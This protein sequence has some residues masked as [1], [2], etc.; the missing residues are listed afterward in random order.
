M[1][2]LTSSTKE[3]RQAIS[4]VA[5]AVYAATGLD[6]DALYLAAHGSMAGRADEDFRNFQK[7]TLAHRKVAPIYR[8][9]CEHYLPL[10]T[11]LEPEVFDPSLLT[12]WD[13]FVLDHGVYGR[14]T[15]R[16]IG[17]MGLTERSNRQPIADTPIR[18]GQEFVFDV[19]C[20]LGGKM[21][22]LERANGHT[23]P[24]SLHTDQETLLIDVQLGMQSAP[25]TAD[26]APDPLRE[27]KHPGFRGYLF[28]IGQPDTMES[29]VA[30]LRQAQPIGLDT[31][32]RMALAFAK[33]ERKE[34]EPFELHRLNVIFTPL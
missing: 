20:G 8:W 33:P 22:A 5:S 6:F 3:Q 26:G 9:I 17:G 18:L 24:F 30:G 13:D 21:L 16:L 11:S 12:R 28:L 23:Y 1:L 29:C 25:V 7:G 34:P 4:R 32:D 10:A 31:L 27:D 19:E 14:L 15:H 2:E